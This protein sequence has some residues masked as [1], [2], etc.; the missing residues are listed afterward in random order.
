MLKGMDKIL[1]GD[2]LKILCDMGHGD[3]LVIADTNFPA[4]GIAKRLI[5]YPGI[6]A[7][8]LLEAI[9]P[10]FPLDPYVDN[11]TGVMELTDGDKAN[12][13]LEPEVWKIYSDILKK[14]DENFTVLA[15]IEREA[16]YDRARRAYAVIQTGEERL[17]G[18]LLL[19]KGVV[20]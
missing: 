13:M 8:R 4:D 7:G 5:R 16:F 9:S 1:T 14:N 3:E 17:Y 19:R 2:I 10:L 6:D 15:H 20:K 11:P 18:N 12:G